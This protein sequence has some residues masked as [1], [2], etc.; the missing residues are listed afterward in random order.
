MRSYAVIIALHCDDGS[1][2]SAVTGVTC[3]AGSYVS[4]VM[5]RKG[6]PLGT[7]VRAPL[8]QLY[9]NFALRPAVC[10]LP[11]P[12]KGS[13]GEDAFLIGPHMVGVADGVGSW[14]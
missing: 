8:E 4:T 7:R 5:R 3:D 2:V 9:Q 12:H 11:H 10:N 13:A 14:W 1:S 6:M